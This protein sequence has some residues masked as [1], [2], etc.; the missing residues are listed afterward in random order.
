VVIRMRRSLITLGAVF[1]CISAGL[2]L[3]S[4]TAGESLTATP[5]F[6]QITISPKVKRAAPQREQNTPNA[7]RTEKPQVGPRRAGQT[8]A[9]HSWHVIE[10]D[11]QRIGY[12]HSHSQRVD[13]DGP[14]RIESS[15]VTKMVIKRFGQTISMQTQLRCTEALDGELLAYE[16]VMQNPPADPTRSTGIVEGERLKIETTVSGKSHQTTMPWNHAKSPTYQDRLLREFRLKPGDSKRIDVFAPEY[17]KFGTAYLA[18][19]EHRQVMLFD[20][21]Q[22]KLLKVVITQSL[23]PTA[24]IQAFVDEA[25]KVLKTETGLLGKRLVSYSVPEAEAV[26]AIAGGNLDIAVDSLVRVKP[27]RK[28][29]LS[30]KVVYRIRTPQRNPAEFIIDGDTQSI[31]QIDDETI[32]LTVTTAIASKDAP[33]KVVADEY[34]ISTRYLQSDDARVVMHARTAAAGNSLPADVALRLERYVHRKVKDKNFSTALA[35]AAEVARTLEG[36]CTE[37]AVL[38]AAMLRARRVPSR[39]AVG[40]VYVERI[41]AFGGH[42]WTEAWINDRWIPL[43]ATLGRGGIGAAHI[44]MAQS[45]FAD[46]AP[47]PVTMFLPL[48]SVLGEIQIEVLS[49]K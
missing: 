20:G 33:R 46:D 14:V 1:A 3:L 13:D 27:I 47:A 44:K 16:F 15:E 5:V 36:D 4:L 12:S 37:H 39:V 7:S 2:L 22:R 19:E 31:R 32:E 49:A 45:S 18:A 28:G 40:L 48:V 42:M 35:S 21:T 24:P 38:L 26:K 23:L 25:G 30:Q 34:L 11:G 8:S 6:G 29:H 43:D 17:G 9:D 41:A 10:L